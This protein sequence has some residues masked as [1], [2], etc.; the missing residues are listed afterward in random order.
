MANVKT[1]KEFDAMTTQDLIKYLDGLPKATF[2]AYV[3]AD[4]K[5]RYFIGKFGKIFA[6]EIEGTEL[7]FDA[8]V[9]QSIGESGWGRSNACFNANNFGGVKYNPNIHSAYWTSSNGTKWAKW[10]TPEEGIKGHI[11]VLLADR[12]AKA[13]KDANSPE[14]QIKMFVS[15]G[16]DPLLSPAK[17]LSNIQGNI[18]RVRKLTGL[19]RISKSA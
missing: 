8:V 9:P 13:R 18:N 1:K 19:G 4:T 11:S 12:Y 17:Y 5:L 7:F 10:N 15:A 2:D 6:K 3:D 16:Y 14:Q